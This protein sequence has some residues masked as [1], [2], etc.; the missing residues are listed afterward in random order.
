M[1]QSK[2]CLNSSVLGLGTKRVFLWPLDN[3]M[4]LIRKHILFY[5]LNKMEL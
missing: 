5:L 1:D 4:N 3:S 2:Q